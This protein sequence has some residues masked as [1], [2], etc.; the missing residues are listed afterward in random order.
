MI[1]EGRVSPFG[2]DVSTEAMLP[3]TLKIP[4]GLSPEAERQLI[5]SS[6]MCSIR[7][8]WAAQ[9]R[10]GG[11]IVA[12][13]N[14][15]CGSSRPGHR[16]LRALGIRGVVAESVSRPFFRNFISVRF[17][18]LVCPG[19]W[20]LLGEGEIARVDFESGA[21]RNVV[22]DRCVQGIELPSSS[23]PAQIVRAGGL[24]QYLAANRRR[25]GV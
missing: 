14:F 9:V 25:F 18:V 23:P 13:Q 12:A 19:A 7:P 22:A 6:C 8:G 10:E 17:P 5:T 1:V 2:R 24:L 16:V 15:G 11:V 20:S 3:G 4:G 21:V